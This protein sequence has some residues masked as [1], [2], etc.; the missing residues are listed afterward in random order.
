MTLEVFLTLLFAVSLLVGLTV[1]ALKKPLSGKNYSYNI[2]A[3]I[4]SVVIS[5]VVGVFYCIL[6]EVAFS[7]QIIIYLIALVFLS[8]LCAMLVYDKVVQTIMQIKKQ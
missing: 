3:S 8:W 7:A 1:E 5:A 2:L 6:A 4:V